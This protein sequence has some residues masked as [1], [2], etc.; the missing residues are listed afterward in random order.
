MR[1]KRDLLRR[2]IV[3][4]VALCCTMLGAVS[5]S[6]GIAPWHTVNMEPG[7]TY[8]VSDAK[9][10]TTVRIDKDGEFCLTGSSKYCRVVVG[11]SNATII[12]DNLDLRP[13]I[14]SNVGSRTGSITINDQGGTVTLVSK[15][16]SIN[17]FASYM[18]APAI[19]KDSPK[20][21][22]VFE[23]ENPDNPGTINA[24]PNSSAGTPGIGCLGGS[25]NV[26]GNIVFNSGTVNA[27]GTKGG[28]GIGAGSNANVDGITINGG[29]ITASSSNVSDRHQNGQMIKERGAGIGTTYKGTARNITINGGTVRAT[30][31]R[32]DDFW[33]SYGE[34]AGIGGGNLSG[35]EN[36]TIN[37]GNVYARG[38]SSLIYVDG[39]AHCDSVESGAAGIGGGNGKGALNIVINGGTVEASGGV[40]ACG[41]G[42]GAVASN[43][44]DTSVKITGGS[45][46]AYAD[47]EGYGIGSTR[48]YGATSVVITGGTVT[49][50]GGAINPDSAWPTGG[51]GIGAGSPDGKDTIVISGGHINATGTEFHSAI[52]GMAPASGAGWYKVDEIQMGT[53][54]ISGGT[55]EAKAEAKSAGAVGAIGSYGLF[56]T[57]YDPC[58]VFISGGSIKCGDGTKDGVWGSPKT[59][60]N[61]PDVFWTKAGFEGCQIGSLVSSTEITGNEYRYGLQDVE[62]LDSGSENNNGTVWFYI[63]ESSSILRAD[64]K[65]DNEDDV[66]YCGNVE[67][68]SEGILARATKVNLIALKDG[69]KGSNG[70]AWTAKGLRELQIIVE[71]N[72][73]GYKDI[74]DYVL[75]WEAA[76]PQLIVRDKKILCDDVD[77]YT[78]AGGYWNRGYEPDGVSVYALRYPISFKLHFDS[79]KPAESAEEPSGSIGDYDMSYGVPR[80]LPMDRLS[81]K[82]YE[83][84]GWSKTRG[85]GFLVD[86]EI[87]CRL[88]DKEGDTAALYAHWVPKKYTVTYSDGGEMQKTQEMTYNVHENLRSA[89][90][91]EFRKEGYHFGGWTTGGFGSFYDDEEEVC[92]LCTF[93]EGEIKGNTLTAIWIPDSVVSVAVTEDG[94]PV[95]NLENKIRLTSSSGTIIKNLCYN[96]DTGCYEKEA[97]PGGTYSI[98][99]DGYDTEGRT[100][101]IDEERGGAAVLDYY[102]VSA[103]PYGPG[104]DSAEIT[105][106][107]EQ[108]ESLTA[109]SENTQTLEKVPDG[110]KVF[111]CTTIADDDY[112]FDRY[113]A[114]GIQPKWENNDPKKAS[115]TLTI[116]GRTNIFA[117]IRQKEYTIVFAKN[118]EDAEGETDSMKMTCGVAENLQKCGFAREGYSFKGWTLTEN[119]AGRTYSDCES[120]IDLT[121]EDGAEVTLYAQWTPDPYF[122]DF[123]D[124]GSLGLM[125]PQECFRDVSSELSPNEYY[126][127]AHHFTGWNTEAD[128][129][130]KN[131]ADRQKVM[132]LVKTENGRTTLFA[133][134]KHD[135]Y[136]IRFD[137]NGGKGTMAEQEMYSG[138]VFPLNLNC[139][140][141]KGYKFAGWSVTKDGHSRSFADGEDV[142]DLAKPGHSLT[143]YAQWIE[144]K[145]NNKHK[146]HGAMTGDNAR[147]FLA[148]MLAAAAVCGGILAL[149]T[150][151]RRKQ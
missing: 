32:Q 136:S 2:I 139:F 29:N 83:L 69:D 61:G 30:G 7:G 41:I 84:E 115:Q 78:G 14:Y 95:T 140:T 82:G 72:V 60:K 80:E 104:S 125:I 15:E 59:E 110:S 54:S 39:V 40:K 107:R 64:V 99:I 150:Q 144:D 43:P 12:L 8:N 117:N 120:V 108:S 36:I 24:V 9:K 1:K 44:M 98:S 92:N 130:G 22:L 109:A 62:T 18:G 96:S 47:F 71:P 53:I 26:A 148:I 66:V 20:T 58:D 128:G 70:S 52:G 81:L 137:A 90:S 51:S 113:S 33:A 65:K 13:G 57:S 106:S 97:V 138:C 67:A 79:N 5:F 10:N 37:G 119:W 46:T 4:A 3:T 42:S 77:G 111:I 50:K 127:P 27:R 149:I 23:T 91:L 145:G 28:A 132:N 89:E 114:S 126:M 38:G 131:Y 147:V 19:R 45:V 151:R 49:A 101:E 6:Y 63:P 141:R 94:E 56:K 122:I 74:K 103:Q 146:G 121:K 87:A 75:D 105:L 116:Q 100:I 133:Q 85:G 76:D 129:T 31:C 11:S 73:N 143:L 134:W 135:S 21:K 25:G 35:A 123:D 88:T 55:I 16:G 86:S 102:T 68:K 34:G 112:A 142:I 93:E 124:N 48:S 118:A 17:N